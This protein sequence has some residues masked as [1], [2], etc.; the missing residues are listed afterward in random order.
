MSPNSVPQPITISGDLGS[1]KSTVSHI[2]ARELG[3]K[4]YSTGDVQR[5]LASERGMTSLEFNRLAETDPEIDRLIDQGTADL[6]ATSNELVVDSRL[7]W[8]FVPSS[9]KV[10]ISV[11]PVVAARRIFEA[12][13]GEVENYGSMEEA[14]EKL[15]QRRA[16][17]AE[18]FRQYYDLKVESLRNFDLVVDSTFHSPEEVADLVVTNYRSLDGPSIF[19]SPA[20]IFPL[21]AEDRLAN[22]NRVART[23]SYYYL[24]E[25]PPRGA[26]EHFKVSE[27]TFDS[28]ELTYELDELTDRG[29]PLD[30]L[31]SQRCTAALVADW[32]RDHGFR[33]P[34]YPPFLKEL[35]H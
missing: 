7:A 5:K 10:Y 20:V 23:G 12:R 1:G 31:V 14:I 21:S 25:G 35:P 26:S 29:L 27:G 6:A 11:D 13:R 22:H 2:L 33:F 15:R 18:R 3:Y 28:A 9:F 34:S 17:E 16:S 32:E 8:H 4:R 24:Y 30:R 19:L